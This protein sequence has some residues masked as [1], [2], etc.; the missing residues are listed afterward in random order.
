MPVKNSVIRLEKTKTADD[1]FVFSED[2]ILYPLEEIE[3]NGKEPD[4]FYRKFLYSDKDSPSVIKQGTFFVVF[5]PDAND[6]FEIYALDEKR[7]TMGKQIPE[8]DENIN[9]FIPKT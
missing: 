6:I 3:C 7:N 1:L 9:I 8:I 5:E 4:I 2:Y